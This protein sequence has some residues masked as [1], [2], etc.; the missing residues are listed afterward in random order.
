M[1]RI[2]FFYIWVFAGLGLLATAVLA[3][4]LGLDHNAGWGLG[5]LTML[6]A[7]A[8]LLAVAAWSKYRANL[9]DAL[10]LGV[11]SALGGLSQNRLFR[12]L[13][14]HRL[15]ALAAATT[16]LVLGLYL[17]FASAGTWS[18]WPEYSRYYDDLAT[19]FRAGHLYLGIQPSTAFLALSDPYEPAARN[20]PELRA[21]VDQVYDLSFYRGRFYQYRGPAPALLLLIVKLFYPGPIADQFLA[22]GFL[23]G[24]LIFTVLLILEL[25]RGLYDDVPF[26]LAWI[27]ILAAALA[28]PIPWMLSNAGIYEATIS[29]GQFFLIGG[30]YFA[31]TGVK[32]Q[33]FSQARLLAAAVFW[34]LASASRLT[35]LVPAGFLTFML[36]AWAMTNGGQTRP[37][38]KTIPRILILAAPLTVAV[39]ALGLY[40]WA[41]FGSVFE[42]GLRYTLGFH[43]LD[44]SY[45]ESFSATYALPGMWM[46]LFHPFATQSRFPFVLATSGKSPS[47]LYLGETNI[48]HSAEVAGL[49]FSVPFVLFSV[50]SF[51]TAVASLAARHFKRADPTDDDRGKRLR[52]VSACLIGST[53]LSFGVVLLYFDVR[54]RFLADFVPSLMLLSILGA[55]QGFRWMRGKAAGRWLFMLG[56][57]ALAT[58]SV[59]LGLLLGMAENFGWFRKYNPHLIKQLMLFFAR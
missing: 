34:A 30:L 5:R 19:A 1:K 3:T 41:R 26:S 32:T 56:T 47:F 21:F 17:F 35:A 57:V 58:A 49:L 38:L 55:F 22:F 54:M 46:Y 12:L 45:A 20:T 39:V 43:N 44:R 8:L 53:I 40:N 2:L 28:C 10:P 11:R 27:G 9:A 37:I 52:W 14:R 18:I 29:G 24:L 36:L 42:S 13:S 33:P 48:Y 51:A 25:W 31:W 23:S 15:A 16:L 6:G 50:V 59:S 4:R 7:G